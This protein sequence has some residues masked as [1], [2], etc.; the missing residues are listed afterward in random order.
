[1]VRKNREF[2]EGSKKTSMNNAHGLSIV[3]DHVQYAFPVD[4]TIIDMNY[5]FYMESGRLF[6]P[7]AV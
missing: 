6:L 5:G 1:M 2:P 4:D 7:Y 3:H